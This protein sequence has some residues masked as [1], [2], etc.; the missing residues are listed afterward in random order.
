M[1]DNQQPFIG[2]IRQEAAHSCVCVF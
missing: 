2:V 1:V